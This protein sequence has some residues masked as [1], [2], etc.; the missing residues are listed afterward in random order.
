[1]GAVLDFFSS[2]AGGIASAISGNGYADL[3]QLGLNAAGALYNLAKDK[4]N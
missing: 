1:M 4:Y 3:I 2:L